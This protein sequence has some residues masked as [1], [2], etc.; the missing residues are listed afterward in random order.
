MK[1]TR[2]VIMLAVLV[3][4]LS[5]ANGPANGR[6]LGQEIKCQMPNEEVQMLPPLYCKIWGGKQ[7]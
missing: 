1:L 6:T 3:P 5:F 2:L 7:L 4:T